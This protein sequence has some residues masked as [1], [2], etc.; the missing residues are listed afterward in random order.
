M[1]RH[2]MRIRCAVASA[3]LLLLAAVLGVYADTAATVRSEPALPQAMLD[4]PELAG[5]QSINLCACSG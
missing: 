3:S 1:H 4:D 5:M 2:T